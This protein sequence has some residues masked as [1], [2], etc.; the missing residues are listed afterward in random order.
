MQP[1]GSTVVIATRNAGKAREFV[2]LFGPLGW[3]VRTLNDYPDIPDIV[4]DGETFADNALIKAKAVADRLGVPALA[5]DSGL[6]VDALDGRPGVYSA[7]YAGEGA[8]DADNIAKLLGEL[9]GLAKAGRLEPK[10]ENVDGT[11]V[12]LLS[13][14]RFVCSLALYDPH[15]PLL[16]VEGQCEGF[17][18]DRP[19]GEKG[20]GYDPLFYVPEFG[21]TFAGLP[22]ERKNAVSHRARALDKLLRLLQAERPV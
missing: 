3:T 22:M 1:N 15:K 13:T 12:R 11:A 10:P 2:S 14:A 21:R 18:I 7:R 20:F 4:E 17:I 9:N 19:L 5:D 6:C 16:Q 8:K